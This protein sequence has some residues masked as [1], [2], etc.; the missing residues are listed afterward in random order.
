MRLLAE[1]GYD[2]RLMGYESS[3]G[4]GNMPLSLYSLREV[5]HFLRGCGGE[6]IHYLDLGAL[7]QW[8][9][10][11]L[12]DAALQRAIGEALPEEGAYFARAARVAQVIG[13]RLEQAEKAITA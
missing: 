12:G 1:V 9:G 6:R 4:V 5:Y 8:V 7:A 11:V 10:E 2:E 13:E 3:P